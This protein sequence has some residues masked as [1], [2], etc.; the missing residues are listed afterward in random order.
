MRR[1]RN[2]THGALNVPQVHHEPDRL[3]ASLLLA[4]FPHRGLGC[5]GPGGGENQGR[6]QGRRSTSIRPVPRNSKT[7]LPGVG[8]VTAKKIVAG[9]LPHGHRRPSPRPAF[10]LGSYRQHPRPGH[11]SAPRLW[12]RRRRQRPSP[13]EKATHARPRQ[14]QHGH[15]RRAGDLAGHR[16]RPRQGDHREPALQVGR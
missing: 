12:L 16:S 10:L 1:T 3:D 9:T 7:I 13:P 11:P 6:G 5:P 14:S 4:V 8:A 15:R 2:R